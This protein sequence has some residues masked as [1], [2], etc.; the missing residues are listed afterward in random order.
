MT[1]FVGVGSKVKVGYVILKNIK[2]LPAKF[3]LL[4][5]SLAFSSNVFSNNTILVNENNGL[6]SVVGEHDESPVI[7]AHYVA[8]GENWK[9]SHIKVKKTISKNKPSSAFQGSVDDLGINFESIINKVENTFVW[10]YKWNSY[11]LSP[12]AIG[13]G[14]EFSIEGLAS[15]AFKNPILLPN[16]EG[17]KIQNKDGSI[18]TMKFEPSLAEVYFEQGNKQRIRAMFK[19]VNDSE[20][21]ETKMTVSTSTELNLQTFSQFILDRRAEWNE[22]ILPLKQSPTDLS[23]LNKSHI[24]AGRHGRVMADGDKLVFSDGTPA[25]FWGTNIQGRAIFETSDENIK[26]HAKRI[27]QL[28]FNLVRFHHHDSQ[29]VQPNIFKTG[30]SELSLTSLKN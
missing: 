22:N 2:L 7:T 8:W 19:K 25:S 20:I 26:L 27:S 13:L 14:I 16:N 24:P 4:T 23:Y 17:W 30:S 1:R 12:K 10:N 9:W 5:I 15:G 28:G 3:F 29:W 21:R 6:F 18:I 11:Q